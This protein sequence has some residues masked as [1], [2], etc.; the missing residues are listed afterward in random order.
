[1][2]PF[3]FQ[4]VHFGYLAL[5]S[6]SL[7]SWTWNLDHFS[8]VASMSVVNIDK[9]CFY[10]LIYKAQ[11]TDFGVYGKVILIFLQIW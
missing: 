11:N 3:Q 5:K 1:M 4:H 6:T 10:V 9:K 7:D 2:S 8:D